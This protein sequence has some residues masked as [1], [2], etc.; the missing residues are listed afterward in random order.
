MIYTRQ[1]VHVGAK[2][3]YNILVTVGIHFSKKRYGCI[4]NEHERDLSTLHLDTK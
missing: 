3:M 4:V 1:Y 2:K